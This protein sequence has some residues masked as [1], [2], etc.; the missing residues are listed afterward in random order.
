[1]HLGPMI[2]GVQ[3]MRWAAYLLALAIPLGADKLF[4]LFY[5]GYGPIRLALLGLLALFVLLLWR[6]SPRAWPLSGGILLRSALA[7]LLL[8]F[9]LDNV[10]TL[11]WAT[12]AAH[13][14]GRLRL[15]EGRTTLRAAQL[16]WRGENP[17]ATG[18]LVD[19]T[20]FLDRLELRVAAG[21]GPE[22]SP[23]QVQP[24]LDRYLADL[25]PQTRTTLLPPAPVDANATARR[26]VALLGYKYGPV[27]LLI[28]TAL[29]KLAGTAAVPLSNG[30]ACLGLFA[31]VGAILLTLGAGVAASGV[32][33]VGLMLDPS[34]SYYF[35][36]LTAADIWP[37]LFGFLA[38]LL[39]LR[40]WHA[41]SGIALALALASKIVLGALF[42]LLLPAMRSGRVAV[43]CAGATSVLLLPWLVLD[44]RGFVQDFMLWGALMAP[45]PDTWVFWAPP[46]LV[47][48]AR[49][50]LCLPLAW[51]AWR[52]VFR[53]EQRLPGA[54]ALINML[55]IA[56]GSTMHNTYI[57]WSMIWVVLAIA[58]ALCL[59]RL[60]AW[61][62]DTS[63]AGQPQAIMYQSRSGSD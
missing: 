60:L 12:H 32:A 5:R 37:L 11:R 18:A 33:V 34:I 45:Y 52:I 15:D 13:V 54:F 39:G 59:P 2:E 36:F 27:P 43:W 40:G 29:E 42:L 16:L 10:R 38:L 9:A 35:I 47:L 58:E 53:R 8:A 28:V 3:A 31:T 26:E 20:A 6:I 57:I 62:L 14:T 63:L 44:A 46:G 41:G 51:L 7:V 61:Q 56:G 19:D 17:Y 48:A 25:D 23:E 30:L 50:A 1:M 24:A 22:L 49:V 21:V 55:L 4:S